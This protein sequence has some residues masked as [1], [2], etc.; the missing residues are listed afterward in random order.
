MAGNVV[1]GVD[2][3][4]TAYKAAS[5]A[6]TLAG[7]LGAELVVLSAHITGNT[8]IVKIGSETWILDDAERALELAEDVAAK[9]RVDHPTV[10]VRPAAGRGKPQDVLME[11]AERTGAELLVVGNVGVKGLGR[12]LGSVAW[13]VVHNAPCDVLVVKT[14]S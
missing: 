10:T 12:V 8:E 4:D 11:E 1:V 5:R 13:S 9:L 3:S 7:Q 2:G 14:A 6:A